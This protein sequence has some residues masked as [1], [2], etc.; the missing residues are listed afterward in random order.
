LV[1]PKNFLGPSSRVM[2]GSCRG[3]DTSLGGRVGCCCLKV[4]L[5]GSREATRLKPIR[6][7]RNRPTCSCRVGRGR[8]GA[9]QENVGA[10]VVCSR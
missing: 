5:V 6:P 4:A 10:R 8:A 9:Q 2:V 1:M 3:P 7:A